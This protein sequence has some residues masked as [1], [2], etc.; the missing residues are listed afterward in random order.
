MTLQHVLSAKIESTYGFSCKIMCIWRG[1][2]SYVLHQMAKRGWYKIT[3]DQMNNDTSFEIP[4]QAAV[5]ELFHVVV[6]NTFHNLCSALNINRLCMIER[7]C[8]KRYPRLLTSDEIMGTCC[9]DVDHLMIIAKRQSL[10]CA[11]GG[12]VLFIII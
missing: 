5:A 9:I 6:K 11:L 4:D 8:S 3:P 12:S 10:E 7:K 2:L 1:V